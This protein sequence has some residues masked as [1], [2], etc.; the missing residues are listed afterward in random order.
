M[1]ALFYIFLFSY[2]ALQNMTGSHHTILYDEDGI[3]GGIGC[4][5]A[6]VTWV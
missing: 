1:H 3:S 6:V 4:D 5:E 2:D